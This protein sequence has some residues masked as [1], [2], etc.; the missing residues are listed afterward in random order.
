VLIIGDTAPEGCVALGPAMAAP[1]RFET[2]PTEPE[3]MALLHFTSGT[4]GKPKGVV[5]VHEAVVAH[6]E[7]GRSRSTCGRATSTGAPPIRAG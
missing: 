2:V 5:H 4:T 7:T 1:D 3:D 6:A